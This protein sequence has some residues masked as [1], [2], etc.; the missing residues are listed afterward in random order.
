MHRPPKEFFSALKNLEEG[1]SR[2]DASAQLLHLKKVERFGRLCTVMGYATA[3]IAPN[4]ISAYLIAQG[5]FTRWTSVAHHAGDDLY[6]FEGK[7]AGLEEFQWRQILGSTNYQ[8][9]GFLNDALHGYLNYQIEHHLWPDKSMMQYRC[10]QPRVKAL[11]ADYQVPYIQESVWIRLRE[12]LL[13]MLGRSDMKNGLVKLI[14][15]IWIS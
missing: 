15:S 9:G 5:K 1:A 11:C 10:L 3:W 7:P 14:T 6:R 12:T 2:L 13:I 8:T 4:P